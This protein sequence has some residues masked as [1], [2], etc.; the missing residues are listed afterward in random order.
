MWSVTHK[1][2]RVLII[3]DNYRPYFCLLPR[4]DQDPEELGRRLESEKPHPA[5]EN[6]SI[7]K[8]KLLADERVVLQVFCKDTELLERAARD[9]L[10]KTGGE[11]IYEEKLR[12]A[13]KYQYDYEIKPCQW[14]EVETSASTIDPKEFNVQET[15]TATDH[16]RPIAKEEPPAL[17]LFSFSLLSVSKTG[18][19]SAIRDP[20]RIIS[21]KTPK[22]PN[23][24]IE[25]Q[26]V[27][28]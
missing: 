17:D 20:I 4:K 27:S 6:V 7:E 28:H 22:N 10:K 19:P 26:T 12:L 25:T 18:A 11:D 5:I 16:P 13:I 2:R 21:W 1:D 3:D 9:T 23:D 8:K 14:Y 15:L 24:D